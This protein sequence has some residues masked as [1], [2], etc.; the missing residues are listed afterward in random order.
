VPAHEKLY[1]GQDKLAGHYRR[2]NR[3]TII[4]KLEKSGFRVEIIQCFGF[5]VANLYTK[6][7]NF[8]LSKITKNNAS[9]IYSQNTPISGIRSE[10]SHFPKIIGKISVV[11]F[12]VLSQIIKIDTLFLNFN[13]GTH[14]IIL[15]KKDIVK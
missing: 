14:Y 9:I 5:P 3:E 2:Y 4:K 7:Y 10:K 1:S 15:A 12:P 6:L 13:L 11:V 8:Y